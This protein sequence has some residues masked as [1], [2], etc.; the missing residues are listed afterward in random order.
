MIGNI[1]DRVIIKFNS[2]V[3]AKLFDI[4]VIL[5]DKHYSYFPSQ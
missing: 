1:V 2:Q 3:Y 4:L 5:H